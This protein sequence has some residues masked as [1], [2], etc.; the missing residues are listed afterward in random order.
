MRGPWRLALKRSRFDRHLRGLRAV[1]LGGRGLGTGRAPGRRFTG[2]TE[3]PCLLPHRA[4]ERRPLA[5]RQPRE[6]A[7]TSMHSSR[8]PTPSAPAASGRRERGVKPGSVFASSITGSASGSNMRG[9][10]GPA[11]SG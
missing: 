6:R 2:K 9:D 11:P 3:R 5:P 10:C 8:K 4:V 1:P 7:T